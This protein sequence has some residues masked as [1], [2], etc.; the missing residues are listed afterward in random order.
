MDRLLELLRP[1]DADL[2]LPDRYRGVMLGVATGN[3]LGIEAEGSSAE[4]IR[5]RFGR[6][7]E[8]PA[9]E[10]SQDWDDDVAQTLII[11]DLVDDGLTIPSLAKQFLEWRE[12]SGR[13]IGLLTA[14]V[15]DELV[16]G[17]APNRA[18][19]LV[20]E[21]G[22]KRSAGNGAVMRCWPVALRWRRLPERLIADA[23]TSALVTHYDPRCEWSTVAAVAVSAVALNRRPLEVDELGAALDQAGVPPEV[24][25]AIRGASG[26]RL[27]DL[28]LD[29]PHSM[30]Y[31]LKALQVAVWCM[32]QAPAFERVISEV[33]NAGGDTDTNGAVAGAVMGAR[34]GASGIPDRWTASLF[35]P[36]VLSSTADRLLSRSETDPEQ[37]ERVGGRLHDLCREPRVTLSSGIVRTPLEPVDIRAILLDQLRLPGEQLSGA[38]ERLD[39]VNEFTLLERHLGGPSPRLVVAFSEGRSVP[40]SDL[41]IGSLDFENGTSFV[42]VGMNYLGHPASIC[43]ALERGENRALWDAFFVDLM[44]NNGRDYGVTLL[45]RL[46]PRIQ[47]IAG[48]L[49]DEAI[50]RGV[51]RWMQSSEGFSWVDLAERMSSWAERIDQRNQLAAIRDAGMGPLSENDENWMLDAYMDLSYYRW[52][53]ER[54]HRSS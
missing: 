17:T 36:E 9:T 10:A 26:S 21:G 7:T 28:D 50:R 48:L 40:P 53:R 3:A 49:S 31:T 19:R 12:R 13:G 8:I 51:Q 30:G 43:A 1:E 38:E 14:Q 20:W 34:T 41:L 33:V 25:E 4:D 54:S 39:A 18:A 52:R 15:L 11:A 2:D 45:E 44:Q 6:I 5:A 32:E 22:G 23:R 29:D 16:K 37:V 35:A 47:N 46:P 27:D 24:G 42:Y